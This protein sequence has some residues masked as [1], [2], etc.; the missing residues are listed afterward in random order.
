VVVGAA[1]FCRASLNVK[2]LYSDR[3]HLNARGAAL[4]VE[5]IGGAL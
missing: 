4:L 1:Y 2:P 5:P 3:H